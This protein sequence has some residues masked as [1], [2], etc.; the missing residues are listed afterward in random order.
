MLTQ[1]Q[2]AIKKNVQVQRARAVFY[3]GQAVAPKFSLHL[4]Q[5][6]QQRARR[7]IGFERHRRIQKPRLL[8]HPHRRG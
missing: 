3:A 2:V 6:F 8:G 1:H 5:T 4:Q 7:K